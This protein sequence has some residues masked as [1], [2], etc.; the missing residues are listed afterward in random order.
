VEA[1]ASDELPS[2]IRSWA[3]EQL[4]NGPT[5]Y[6]VGPL[7]DLLGDADNRVVRSAA[8]SLAKHEDPRVRPALEGLKQHDA[9]EVRRVAEASLARLK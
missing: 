6:A 5:E 2:D 8:R 3:V 4:G 9:P 7:I 1:V